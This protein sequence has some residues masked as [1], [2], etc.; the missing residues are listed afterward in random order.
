MTTT[1][2]I[3]NILRAT[4]YFGEAGYFSRR[5]MADRLFEVA[6]LTLPEYRAVCAR[7]TEGKLAA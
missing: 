7:L 2:N 1:L 5:E 6:L 3:E 4:D